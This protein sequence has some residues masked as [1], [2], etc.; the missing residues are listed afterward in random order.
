MRFVP[1]AAVL[2]LASSPAAAQLS[3]VWGWGQSQCGNFTADDYEP[4]KPLRNWILGALSGMGRATMTV[5][6]ALGTDSRVADKMNW[7]GETNIVE[8]VK[9][10][11]SSV[12]DAPVYTA[13][14]QAFEMMMETDPD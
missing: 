5:D 1:I 6:A 7:W 11:C 12:P 14:I 2:L 10:F 13:V 3:P 8:S 9:G 4:G